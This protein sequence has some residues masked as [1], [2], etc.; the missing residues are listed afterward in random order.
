MWEAEKTR[1]AKAMARVLWDYASSDRLMEVWGRV[2]HAR[3]VFDELQSA[4]WHLTAIPSRRD[5]R[6]IL[7]RVSSLRR[8]VAELDRQLAKVERAVKPAGSTRP[9]QPTRP[10]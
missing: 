10:V 1:A 7:R 9:T 5:V 4:L 3:T 6:L 8:R 2:Q